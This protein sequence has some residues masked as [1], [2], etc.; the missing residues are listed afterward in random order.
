MNFEFRK[1][2]TSRAVFPVRL[3]V[4]Y[5]SRFGAIEALANLVAEGAQGVGRTEVGLLCVEETSPGHGEGAGDGGAA[6]AN[7]AALLNRMVASDAIVVGSPGYFGSMASAVKRLFEE[8]ATSEFPPGTDKSRPWRQPLFRNKVGAAFTA[9]ATPHGGNEQTLHSILTMFMHLGMIV[10]T[11]GQQQPI[12][13]NESAPYGATAI[14]GP[15]G[16]RT[17][18]DSEQEA[19]RQLGRQVA[20]VAVWL[21]LGQERWPGARSVGN[22]TAVRIAEE[23][24]ARKKAADRPERIQT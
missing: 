17:P 9:T 7:R 15:S 1:S 16:D 2:A 18:T 5:Y 20:E 14:T 11:P 8:C 19:A 22:G 12:L 4:V 23:A 10:V 6:V 3:L 21:R 13:E 24:T